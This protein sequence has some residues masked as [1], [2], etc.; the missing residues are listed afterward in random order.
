MTAYFPLCGVYDGITMPLVGLSV[1]MAERCAWWE[2][3]LSGRG[4]P[5]LLPYVRRVCTVGC[6][7]AVRVCVRAL[8]S[9][10]VCRAISL[11]HVRNRNQLTCFG[12]SKSVRS[13]FDVV[14]EG[15]PLAPVSSLSFPRSRLPS[16]S[17]LGGR[18]TAGAA[19]FA[20]GGGVEEGRG[21]RPRCWLGQLQ[22]RG[23]DQIYVFPDRGTAHVG[24]RHT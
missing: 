19:G 9:M 14:V 3:P 2:I 16:V 4:C 15:A 1:R 23:Q 12:R 24:P 8:P 20:M 18:V 10:Y 11:S 6:A 17:M 22:P 21:A 13:P 5:G 7:Y